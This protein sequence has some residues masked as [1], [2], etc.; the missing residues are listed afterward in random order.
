MLD[1]VLVVDD[2]PDIRDVLGIIVQQE[3]YEFLSA[4]DGAEALRMLQRMSGCPRLIFLDLRMPVMNGWQFREEQ[5]RD[6]RLEGIPV[7]VIT[8]DSSE[9]ARK[10]LVGAAGFLAKPLQLQEIRDAL[11]RFAAVA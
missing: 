11:A 7:V 9:V 6:S 10:G 4:A 2:D 5:L 3:G 8:A 1:S